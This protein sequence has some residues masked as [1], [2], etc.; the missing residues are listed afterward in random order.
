MDAVNADHIVE[1]I[2]VYWR[3]LAFIGGSKKSLLFMA[4]TVPDAANNSINRNA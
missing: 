4:I 2:G 3:S 1:R